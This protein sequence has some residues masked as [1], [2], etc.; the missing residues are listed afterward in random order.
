MS[1]LV[2]SLVCSNLVSAAAVV[3]TVYNLVVVLD[4]VSK[5]QA[6]ICDEVPESKAD[7]VYVQQLV[8]LCIRTI[9]I[10]SST[11]ATRSAVS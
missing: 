6:C 2:E 9:M 1:Q 5:G 4:N 8:L 10:A 3:S 11:A 7:C